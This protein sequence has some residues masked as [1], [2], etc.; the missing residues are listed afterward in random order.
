MKR[1]GTAH[2]HVLSKPGWLPLVSTVWVHNPWRS[3]GAQVSPVCPQISFVIPRNPRSGSAA[4]SIETWS[5]YV[6]EAVRW[7]GEFKCLRLASYVQPPP[8]HAYTHTFQMNS[9]QQSESNESIIDLR[10]SIGAHLY[11]TIL[12]K[13]RYLISP[14][15]NSFLKVHSVTLPHTVHAQR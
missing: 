11:V 4:S 10:S 1:S 6:C 7:N 2:R 12:D 9:S 5:V 14:Q 3:L 15:S 8:T 13:R